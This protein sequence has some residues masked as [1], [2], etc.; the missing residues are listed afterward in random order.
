MAP[1]DAG[2]EGNDMIG[3]ETDGLKVS[4]DETGVLLAVRGGTCEGEERM[5]WRCGGWRGA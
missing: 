2:W 1:S 5:W 4:G 3:L